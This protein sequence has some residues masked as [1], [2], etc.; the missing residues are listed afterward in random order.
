VFRFGE[1]PVLL[2]ERAAAPLLGIRGYGVH[3]NGYVR[4]NNSIYL[5]TAT[6]SASKPTWPS[7]LDHIAAGGQARV[8]QASPLLIRLF[9]SDAL[10]VTIHCV[11]LHRCAAPL[12]SV[13]DCHGEIIVFN[14]GENVY[15]CTLALHLRQHIA[16]NKSDNQEPEIDGQI[17]QPFI[18][19]CSRMG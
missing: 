13:T 2:V 10:Q 11:W 18:L 3:M 8:L 17:T 15:D 19:L 6:R 16:Q 4:K 7:R 9:H 14:H 5:W 12:T 1:D